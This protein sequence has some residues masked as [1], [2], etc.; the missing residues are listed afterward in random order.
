MKRESHRLFTNCSFEKSKPKVKIIKLKEDFK[1]SGWVPNEQANKETKAGKRADSSKKQEAKVSPDIL[2]GYFL[3]DPIIRQAIQ[4]DVDNVCAGY[5]FELN[6]DTTEAESQKELAEKLFKRDNFM[7]KW[8]NL[9][10][11]QGVYDDAYQEIKVYLNEG[12]IIFD[13][14]ILETPTI[15]IKN[16]DNGEIDYYQQKIDG[17]LVAK[18][19][20][21][22][23]IH[24]RFNAFGDR[25]YGLSLL[26]T[27]L[28][29][30]AIRKFIEKYNISIFQNHKPRSLWLFPED[31]DKNTFDANVDLIV[32][33]KNDP[34]KDIFLRGSDIKN[35]SFVNQNEVDFIQGYKL[36][37]EEIIT[38]LG[39]PP[40]MLGLP[41]GSNKASGDTQLQA[42]D[43]KTSAKQENWEYKIN[44]ELMPKL[45]L[46]L[47]KFKTK[48]PH[49]R[50][51]IRELDI[52]NKMKGLV[53][54]NE[55]RLELGKPELDEDEY[56][57]ANQ[58]WKDS[59]P[60]FGGF[61]EETR[62]SV[63]EFE[64]SV[65]EKK[66]IIAPKVLIKDEKSIIQANNKFW[67][68][69]TSET[70]KVINDLKGEEFLKA[71]PNVTS[72]LSKV[73]DLFSISTLADNLINKTII[74]YNKVGNQIGKKLGIQFNPFQEEIDFLNNYNLDLV[75]SKNDRELAQIKQRIE[76]GILNNSS[77]TE[78]KASI[79]KI[80]KTSKR[81]T[82]TLVRTELNRA[83]NMGGLQVMQQSNQTVKKYL[84]IT[85]D[86]RTSPQSKLFSI[87]YPENKAIPLDKEFKII[88][89]GKVYSGQS[90]PFMPNDRDVLVYIVN[91]TK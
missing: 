62:P 65:K 15:T 16:K 22:E 2:R 27:V 88:Y 19:S 78:I 47:V 64:K 68:E 71:M 5:Y 82:E 24:Y 77:A 66:K 87:K 31:M 55:A 79:D 36:A 39:V 50:D 43:R 51:E 25:D 60:S 17:K 21:N 45:G 54:L 7:E 40:I 48:K 46:D 26:S 33:S 18:L 52:V 72:Y 28:H 67:A 8:R 57:E 30:G 69:V 1:K 83:N 14:Y 13:S 38:G 29:S 20:P 49:K 9:A 41:E 4:T 89:K 37:R 42:Y 91:G 59:T 6:E 53:T 23:I 86:K 12:E 80:R 85:F 74:L 70:N 61:E 44:S 58:I 73:I 3:S 10:L 84:N 81:H 90:P 35:S 75:K 32:E 34:N 11:S 56:P 76:V 63:E